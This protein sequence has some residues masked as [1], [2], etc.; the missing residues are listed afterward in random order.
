VADYRCLQS[1]CYTVEH[2]NVFLLS[3][4]PYPQTYLSPHLLSSYSFQCLVTTILFSTCV[5]LA[6]CILQ[7]NEIMRCLSFCERLISCSIHVVTNDRISC[8]LW[9]KSIPLCVCPP[10]SSLSM[11]HL[12][13]TQVV[14]ISWLLCKVLQ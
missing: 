5:R 8:F 13:D 3:I 10:F 14:S 1:P 7:M 6:F 9:L 12:I 2:Q 11:H 4:T